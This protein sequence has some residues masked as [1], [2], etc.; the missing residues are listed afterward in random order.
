MN[1]KKSGYKYQIEQELIKRLWDIEA[2]NSNN[3]WWDDEHWKV[4][5]R[6]DTNI[7]FYICFIVDPLFEGNRNSGQGIYE[8]RAS[9]EFPANWDDISDRISSIDMSKGKFDVK[10]NGLIEGL[11]KFKKER[12]ISK[13][14]L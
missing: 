2:I 9:S 3:E 4:S 1:S 12:T 8:I 7:S 11:E 6:N 13:N 5:L 14:A 10:L